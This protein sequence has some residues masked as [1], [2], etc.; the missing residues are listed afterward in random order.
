MELDKVRK[1]LKELRDAGFIDCN[2]QCFLDKLEKVTEKVVVDEFIVDWYEKYKD[3]FE[4]SLWEWM[5]YEPNREKNKK[6]YLWLNDASNNPVETLVKMKLFGYSV[7]K[8]KKYMIK[9]K[10]VQSGSQYF[11]YDE[12]IEKWYF[13]IQQ[14]S[15]VSRLYHTKKQLKDAGFGWMFNCPGVE[16]EEVGW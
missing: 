10:N 5:R 9:I 16:V 13:G 7:K 1:D 2:I 6:F 8:E 12:V 4:Y 14:E 3:N 11:K 15:S